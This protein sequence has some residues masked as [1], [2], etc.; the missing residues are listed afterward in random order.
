MGNLHQLNLNQALAPSYASSP[1][2]L[3]WYA[4]Y[5]CAQHEKSVAKQLEL[6]SI[7]YFLP[8]YERVSRWKDRRVKLQV[9]LFSG[10]VFVRIE[11]QERLSVL[12]VPG[13]V[14]LVGFGGQPTPLPQEEMEALRNGLSGTFCAKPCPYLELGGNVRIKSGPLAGLQG[15][16][17]RKKG[18]Y[19]FVLSLELIQRSISV[20]VDAVD[21]EAVKTA[22][23]SSLV[24]IP[25]IQK[26]PLWP[27]LK[28][29]G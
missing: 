26:S 5:T 2:E 10:Y 3:H 15:I 7:E 6:R 1:V 4:V 18:T 16:L 22:R 28:R 24:Y 12:Q 20:E 27:P 23:R 13:V 29:Q 11:L 25:D 21:I 14:H 9:P 19:R 8:L 17:R